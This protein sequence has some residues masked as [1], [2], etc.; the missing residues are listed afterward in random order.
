[1][2]YD[3]RVPSIVGSRNCRT[4]RENGEVSGQWQRCAL[5]PNGDLANTDRPSQR[6]QRGAGWPIFTDAFTPKW[7]AKAKGIAA[8]SAFTLVFFDD[9][10]HHQ[11]VKTFHV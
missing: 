7:A 9:L 6:R 11:Q 2:C 5:D 4:I 1:M 10:D 3:T 8:A